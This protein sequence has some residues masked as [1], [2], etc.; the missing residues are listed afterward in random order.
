MLTAL[1]N[2]T[3]RRVWFVPDVSVWGTSGWSEIEFLTV[4]SVD[5]VKSVFFGSVDVGDSA[6]SV[7]FEQLTDFRGNHLPA[8]LTNPRVFVR[9]R[10]ELS[11]YVVG[12]EISSGFKIA[13]D[14]SAGGPVTVDLLVVEMG[15]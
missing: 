8:S 15:D 7:A 3:G 5:S 11:A 6:Q 1:V 12:S 2:V 10:S 13:R 14:Q 4:E 9:P